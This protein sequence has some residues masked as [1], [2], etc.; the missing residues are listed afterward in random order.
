MEVILTKDVDNLG[1]KNEV[2][3]VKDGF[4][5]NF[6]F[7]KKLAIVA[8]GGNRKNLERQI[9]QATDLRTKRVSEARIVAERLAKIH[10][11]V[12]KKAGK[13]GKLYGSV[14]SQEVAELLEAATG[15]AVDR[16]K[17]LLPQHLKIVGTYSVQLRLVPGVSA[18]IKLDV[19][20]DVE[21]EVM[22]ARPVEAPVRA[23]ARDEEPVAEE[24]AAEVPA[25]EE[26]E[27][28]DE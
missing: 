4:A 15:E 2:V 17:L 13:E 21:G 23:R 20:G 6:L 24:A 22:L 7:P 28:S 25:T 8:T 14:T 10:L 26:D 1:I 5:R 18:E 3:K 19:N 16:R 27:A 11:T 12:L 9:K